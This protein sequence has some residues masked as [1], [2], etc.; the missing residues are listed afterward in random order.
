MPAV[1]EEVDPLASLGVS[2][3]IPAQSGELGSDA[4]G[5]EATGQGPTAGEY[6]RCNSGT[7]EQCQGEAHPSA[8]PATAVTVCG[9]R[10]GQ[11]SGLRRMCM[12]ARRR[13]SAAGPS[14]HGV[15]AVRLRMVVDRLTVRV[16]RLM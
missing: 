9:L 8:G 2:H 6:T 15:E 5:S 3:D 10:R 13:C 4:D 14:A 1:L 11:V 12:V 16:W 7:S